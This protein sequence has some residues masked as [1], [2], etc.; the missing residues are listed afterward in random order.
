MFQSDCL[1]IHL[2]IDRMLL[3]GID[4]SRINFVGHMTCL[5]CY[6][7]LRSALSSLDYHPQ[8]NFIQTA[9]IL[10]AAV[11]LLSYQ[12]VSAKPI[13][14]MILEAEL[15]STVFWT[16]SAKFTLYRVH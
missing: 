6:L 16:S 4:L 2:R 14:A 10:L 15:D 12:K 11:F 3:N 1:F 8:Y 13:S 5:K 9:Q 7:L